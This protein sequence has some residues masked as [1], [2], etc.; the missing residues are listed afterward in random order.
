MAGNDNFFNDSFFEM[1]YP[2]LDRMMEYDF[3]LLYGQVFGEQPRLGGANRELK[4]C[5]GCMSG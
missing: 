1:G 5:T 3:Q 4:R 2:A